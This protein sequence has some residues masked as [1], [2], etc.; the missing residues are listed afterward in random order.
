MAAAPAKPTP[1]P[2]RVLI[3]DDDDGVRDVYVRF[4]KHDGH[5]VVAAASGAEAVDLFASQPFDCVVS[6]IMMPGMS[7]IELLR[8][9][10]AYDLDVPVIMAT[11][12]PALDTAVAAVD[13]G[14]ARYLVKPFER[15]LLTST[16]AQCVKLSRIAKLKREALEALGG[17]DKLIGDR[18]GLS[19]RFDSALTS[20]HMLYQPIVR[21]SDKSLYGYEALVRTKEPSIPHPGVLFDVAERL[22]RIPDVSR[23]IR[24]AAPVPF[25]AAPERGRLF[26]NL[27]VHDLLDERLYEAG[28][29]L[30]AIASRVTLEITERA[31]L[32]G[33]HDVR[34]RVETLRKMGFRIAVD[35][36]GA[37]YAGLNSFA[38]LEPEVVKLDMTLVRGIEKSATKQKLVRSMATLCREMGL[39]VVSEGVET[40]DELDCMVA[41]G[42]DIF[43]GY[44][45]GKPGAAFVE[46]KFP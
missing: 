29:P 5:E 30:A 39:D 31:A 41:M 10:R 8:K 42:C 27:H 25:P 35:D 28:T 24:D 38:H 43:Q 20:L 15:S 6:D 36:L 9:I 4:L 1:T 2:G 12:S 14:A 16:V 34:S 23:K 45:F 13:E 11:G 18:A 32:D 3:V 26:I 19:V 7:G 46:P 22:K 33:V 37:G 21:L 40:K 17:P 44:F